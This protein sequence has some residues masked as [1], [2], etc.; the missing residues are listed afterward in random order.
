MRGSNRRHCAG[1]RRGRATLGEAVAEVLKA[2]RECIW[3]TQVA[4]AVSQD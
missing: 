3:L 1:K 4:G 2:E